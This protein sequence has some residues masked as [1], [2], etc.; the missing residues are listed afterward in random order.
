MGISTEILRQFYNVEAIRNSILAQEVYFL[1]FEQEELL[2]YVS[3]EPVSE[4]LWVLHKLYVSPLHQRKHIGNTLMD[5]ALDFIGK[6]IT[7]PITIKLNLNRYNS[8]ALHLYRGKGFKV[9]GED[10]EPLG[11]YPRTDFVMALACKPKKAE[12]Q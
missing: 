10:N 4:E 7:H 2:G 9:I 12:C 5:Y 1:L 11:D 8:P 3:V 6:S